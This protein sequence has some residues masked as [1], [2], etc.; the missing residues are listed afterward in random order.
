VG[1][2]SDPHAWLYPIYAEFRRDHRFGL[3]SPAHQF[4]ALADAVEKH[5]PTK[6]AAM[7]EWSSDAQIAMLKWLS[8]VVEEP[9]NPV[10]EI[11]LWRVRKGQRELTCVAIYLPTGVDVRL[12]EG[13]DFRR[14]QLVLDGPATDELSQRW[15]AALIGN[16]WRVDP[17]DPNKTPFH[18][19]SAINNR[20]KV[21][22]VKQPTGS[23]N[24]LS[25]RYYRVGKVYDVPAALASYL[26]A[27]GFAEI[28]MRNSGGPP[29]AAERRKTRR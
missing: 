9:P 25:L 15:H 20:V 10:N 12:M 18:M 7:R 17:T 4:A 2:S 8:D 19:R 27:E 26:V 29:P 21:R 11:E 13:A 3:L 23:A 22:I 1:V 16:G 5:S 14:T 24:G 28:E 6:G